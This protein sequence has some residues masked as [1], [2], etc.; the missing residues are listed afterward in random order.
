[1]IYLFINNL[2]LLGFL[3]PLY[4]VSFYC[5]YIYIFH[6]LDICYM[7]ILI[8][9][10]WFLHLFISLF[11]LFLFLIL[12][13]LLFALK[14]NTQHLL[15][16]TFHSIQI[17]KLSFFFLNIIFIKSQDFFNHLLFSLFIIIYS[18]LIE[19]YLLLLFLQFLYC[20]HL[21]C[22]FHLLFAISSFQT[23]YLFYLLIFILF[24]LF[25]L[26]QIKNIYQMF[27]LRIKFHV[28]LGY[29]FLACELHLH[30]LIS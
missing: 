6:Y 23:I 20:F 19:V 2:K 13:P 27:H 4:S 8:V 17:L 7:F 12:F 16:F 1:M 22:L 28:L 10:E 18:Y 11:F 15:S 26:F 24:I 5:F 14:D 21:F 30:L 3:I 29:L 25:I 9:I